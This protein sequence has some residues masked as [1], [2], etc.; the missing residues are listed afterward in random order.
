MIINE[1]P[2]RAGY[3]T[4]HLE[5]SDWKYHCSGDVFDFINAL[6]MEIPKSER[7][8]DP[9]TDTWTIQE[10]HRD[11]IRDLKTRYLEDDRQ[12]GLF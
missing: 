3:I 5:R 6:K 8:F 1:H 4:L 7:E 2:T 12:G 10:K 9:E 11:K